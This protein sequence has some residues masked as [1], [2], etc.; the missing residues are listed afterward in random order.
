MTLTYEQ[1]KSSLLQF[2]ND[3]NTLDI[4]AHELAKQLFYTGCRIGET[5]DNTRW[6]YTPE[7]YY[8]LQPEK[9]NNTR[10]IKY[11]DVMAELQNAITNNRL[12]FQHIRATVFSRFIRKIYIYYPVYHEDKIL[13]S[14]LF[15]HYFFKSLWYQGKTIEEIKTI[16]GEIDTKNVQGYIYSNLTTI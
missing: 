2:I 11:I 14:H 12:A 15:R 6:T 3:T 13:T 4:W 5:Y 7:G 16:T 9:R 1:L 10:Q 8:I